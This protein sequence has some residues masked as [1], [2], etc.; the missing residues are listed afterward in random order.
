MVRRYGVR[1]RWW[2]TSVARSFGRVCH[3]TALRGCRVGW[4]VPA[5]SLG[6]ANRSVDL[7]RSGPPLPAW[8]GS[9]CVPLVGAIRFGDEGI[10]PS[11]P[12][13]AQH[14]PRARRVRRHDRPVP[15]RRRADRTELDALSRAGVAL[16]HRLPVESST[17]RQAST[18]GRPTRHPDHRGAL[19]TGPEFGRASRC[20][21]LRHARSVRSAQPGT[22]GLWPRVSISR[23]ASC[24][25][26]TSPCTAD[27]K[28]HD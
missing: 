16:L 6:L 5:A 23:R 13:P 4:P 9:R 1:G 17:S 22:P 26:T 15:P 24:G 21:E 27:R 3:Q 12:Q 8:T 19:A 25:T 10:G 28:P 2:W 18:R 20:A 7:A 14:R 11:L